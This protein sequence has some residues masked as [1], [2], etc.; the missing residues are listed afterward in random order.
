MLG[1]RYQRRIAPTNDVAT[2]ILR[3]RYAREHHRS[4]TRDVPN[5]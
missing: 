3:V 4:T 5:G 1:Q 2:F